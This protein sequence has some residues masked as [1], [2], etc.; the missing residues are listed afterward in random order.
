MITLHLWKETRDVRKKKER[1]VLSGEERES[2]LLEGREKE[3]RAE[4]VMV[5]KVAKVTGESQM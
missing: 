5:L 2:P 3:G 4:C 1:Q